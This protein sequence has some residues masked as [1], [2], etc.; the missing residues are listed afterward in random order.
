MASDQVVVCQ[1]KSI[2]K[3]PHSFKKSNVS[4]L[5]ANLGS[6][7]NYAQAMGANH[8]TPLGGGGGGGVITTYL[9][10][11]APSQGQPFYTPFL[12][13][14]VPITGQEIISCY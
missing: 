12:T 5:P 1:L 11:E 14:K 6:N 3:T 8:S 7:N 13:E 2:A 10:R 9:Y 4:V